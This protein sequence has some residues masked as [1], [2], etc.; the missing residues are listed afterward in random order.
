M[1]SNTL[2]RN[3]FLALR[4]VRIEVECNLMFSKLKLLFARNRFGMFFWIGLIL[5][6]LGV[7]ILSYANSVVEGH[8]Q[9]LQED[10]SVSERNRIEGSLA[11]WR[12][13]QITLYD[14]MSLILII[15]GTFC[16]AYAC[17]WASLRPTET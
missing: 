5:L 15:V 14:P 1:L 13:A 8:K 6:V 16:I 9:L 10:L 11:W 3:L 12:I 17:A 4:D 7:A 2:A